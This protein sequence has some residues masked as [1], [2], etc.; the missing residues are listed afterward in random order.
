MSDLTSDELGLLEMVRSIVDE[1]DFAVSLD[2]NSNADK[3]RNVRRLGVA[4][5]RIW[6]ATFTGLDHVF[7]LV[8]VIGRALETYADHCDAVEAAK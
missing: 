8:K 7:S 4:V 1:T 3:A 6:A 5:V 2:E